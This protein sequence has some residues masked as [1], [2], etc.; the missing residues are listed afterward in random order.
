MV[1]CSVQ[2][3]G[4]VCRG[5]EFLNFLQKWDTPIILFL[6]L[7]IRGGMNCSSLGYFLCLRDFT[8]IFHALQINYFKGLISLRNLDVKNCQNLPL[9]DRPTNLSL[10]A[11]SRSLKNSC[12]KGDAAELSM[13]AWPAMPT[14]FQHWLS[15]PM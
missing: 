7:L 1:S 5:W 13:L 12:D 6:Y 4:K 2:C 14:L 11:P 9:T 15:V 3:N 8:Y 10:E